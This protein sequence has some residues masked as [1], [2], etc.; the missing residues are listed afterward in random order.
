MR[1]TRE[2]WRI[3]LLK[4]LFSG[5]KIIDLSSYIAGALCPGLLADFGAQV[6]KV[7]SLTGDPF[8]LLGPTFQDWN[9]GKR[10]VCINLKT[11]QGQQ[12]LHKL[13][14]EADVVVEN[15]RPGVAERLGAGYQTLSRINPR[16]I[17]CSISAY[18]Q[19]GPYRLKPGFDPLLQARSGAMAHQGYGRDGPVFLV[20]AISDYAAACL[21]AYGVALAIFARARTGKG[22]R[23][24]TSLLR[25]CMATQSGRFIISR[26]G[27]GSATRGDQY[28]ESSVYRLYTTKDG[29]IFLGVR[30]V[31]E[32]DRLIMALG[33]EGGGLS[34]RFPTQKAR[35]Q[36]GEELAVCLSKIFTTK[37]S[38]EW[39]GILQSQG[40]PCSPVHQVSDLFEDPQ[41]YRNGLSVD[42]KS[43]ELGPITLRGVPVWF[44]ETP[45]ISENA[46]PFLG[47]HTD[48][49]LSGIGY[50]KDQIRSLHRSRV[51]K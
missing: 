7:E 22:R 39:L 6:T 9:R 1:S 5:I 17:Y 8:R 48:E 21:G 13:V 14:K 34:E 42:Y 2:F 30:S 26:N 41:M 35:T 32:W 10:S 16:L 27:S 28:G 24:E 45:G 20:M 47:Q 11:D 15:Y 19:D 51:V 3:A 25:A 33:Q 18:G 29:W 36:S 40:V 49:V 23:I 37:S 12:V 44:S 43:P 46:A 50:S 4:H 31:L 38:N